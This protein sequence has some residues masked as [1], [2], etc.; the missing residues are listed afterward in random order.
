MR[1]NLLIKIKEIIELWEGT[2]RRNDKALQLCLIVDMIYDWASDIYREDVINCLSNY[3]SGVDDT[4]SETE[5]IVWWDAQS[6]VSH[7]KIEQ[8]HLEIYD[9][10]ED[11][12]QLPRSFRSSSPCPPG[13][14]PR[15]PEPEDLDLQESPLGHSSLEGFPRECIS[16]PIV[17]SWEAN[18]IIQ[19]ANKVIFTFRSLSLPETFGELATILSIPS[20]EDLRQ[21]AANLLQLFNLD[22]PIQIT[23]SFISALKNMWT[24]SSDTEEHP[25]L[26]S[27]ESVYAHISFQSYLRPSDYGI[28]REI[29]AITGTS[30]ALSSLWTIA[31]LGPPSFLGNRKLLLQ[32]LDKVAILKRMTGS[33]SLRAAVQ[34]SCFTMTV[35]KDQWGSPVFDWVKEDSHGEYTSNLWI[36]LGHQSSGII[37][38]PIFGYFCA[39]EKICNSDEYIGSNLDE[40]LRWADGEYFFDRG[41]VIFKTPL[42]SRDKCSWYCLTVFDDTD[43]DHRPSLGQKLLRLLDERVL[44]EG[45]LVRNVTLEDQGFIRNW[46]NALLEGELVGSFSYPC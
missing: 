34:N 30:D 42:A 15:T 9:S 12:N 33:N 4:R 20:P 45:H 25:L 26:P 19:D 17:S 1:G 31:K 43:Q 35:M 40:L 41:A 36:N 27:N 46:A 44:F 37:M 28:V 3:E 11:W 32:G 13:S 29:T 16:P 22:R 21:N 39:T 14:F 2:I 10:D 7:S 18:S 24:G 5:S 23:A 38:S 8:T 6:Q